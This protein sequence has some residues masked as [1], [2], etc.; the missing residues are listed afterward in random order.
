MAVLQACQQNN[1]FQVWFARLNNVIVR[2]LPYATPEFKAIRTSI[3]ITQLDGNNPGAALNP[4]QDAVLRNVLTQKYNGFQQA[5][6]PAADPRFLSLDQA[7]SGPDY[8]NLDI[9]VFY[10]RIG[11]IEIVDSR[12]ALVPIPP[13]VIIDAPGVNPN[14]PTQPADV[15]PPS[16]PG[17][18]N[19]NT[20]FANQP[21]Q[22][23]VDQGQVQILGGGGFAA[24]EQTL[25]I[26]IATNLANNDNHTNPPSVI[27]GFDN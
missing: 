12:G 2:Y 23:I 3:F 9:P 25:R 6:N 1:E 20:Y 27:L 22:T 17:V 13:T 8:L 11:T 21:T 14:P 10:H 4:T 18:L 5:G 15:A 24:R 26:S 19:R 16:P 7:V